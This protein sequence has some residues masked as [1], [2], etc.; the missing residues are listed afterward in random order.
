MG[1]PEESIKCQNCGNVLPPHTKFCTKC[2]TE[3]KIGQPPGESIP[4]SPPEPQETRQGE[5]QLQIPQGRGIIET[6]QNSWQFFRTHF[7]QI[8]IGVGVISLISAIA[9]IIIAFIPREFITDVDIPP[10]EGF[11]FDIFVILNVILTICKE[12]SYFW[13]ILPRKKILDKWFSLVIL[14]LWWINLITFG[15][16][17]VNTSIFYDLGGRIPTIF[18]VF[19][20][21]TLAVSFLYFARYRKPLFSST[22]VISIMTIIYLQQ[23][24]IPVDPIMY[25]AI[26]IITAMLLF[27]ITFLTKDLVPTIGVM[28][29]VPGMFLSPYILSNTSFLPISILLGLLPFIDI[30]FTKKVGE[31]ASNF[32]K[33]LIILSNVS[34]LFG[35][36]TLGFTVFYG[37]LSE[38]FFLL[39]LSIIVLM[40]LLLKLRF[41]QALLF[42]LKDWTLTLILLFFVAFFD[43]IEID[44]FILTAIAG[45]LTLFASFN[46][47]EYVSTKRPQVIQYSE[48]LLLATL[49]I[50]SITKIEFIPKSSFFILPLL[51][52]SILLY[53]GIEFDHSTVRLF[54]FGFI[55]LFIMNFLQ[56]PFYNWIIIP[57]YSLIALGGIFCVKVFHDIRNHEG[58]HIDLSIVAILLEIDLLILMLGTKTIS[59]MIYPVMMLIALVILLSGIQLWKPLNEKF[60]WVNSSF[61]ITFGLM[62]FWNEFDSIFTLLISFILLLPMALEKLSFTEL[63]LPLHMDRVNQSHNFNIALAAAGLALI[64]LFEELD[65]ISHTIL[66]LLGPII[67]VIISVQNKI[68]N[69]TNLLLIL[70]PPGFIYLSELVIRS[71]IFT[72]IS[73]EPYLYSALIVITIPAIILQGAK[74]LKKEVFSETK[75]NPFIVMTALL[76]IVITSSTWIYEL[77][78]EVVS[79][80]Y[81]VL[82]V[83]LVISSFLITWQ[84]ESILLVMI[85]FLPS[86]LFSYDVGFPQLVK[87]ILPVIPLCFNIGIVFKRMKSTLAV[88]THETLMVLYL[89]F[90]ILLYPVKI[91]E[92]TILLAALLLISWQILGVLNRRLDSSLLEITNFLNSI[93]VLVLIIFIDSYV[94]EET[95]VVGSSVLELKIIFLTLISGV[96][97]LSMLLHVIYGQVRRESV[98]L[99]ILLSGSIVTNISSLILVTVSIIIRTTDLTFDNIEIGI[100]IIT[101][102]LLMVSLLV[103]IRPSRINSDVITGFILA[104]SLWVLISSSYFQNVEIIFLWIVFAP[105]I[106]A[107]YL[108]RQDLSYL[109]VGIA[110]YTLT[111]IRLLEIILNSLQTGI[112]NWLGILGLIF[113]GVE[114]LSIGIYTVLEN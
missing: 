13:G 46:F 41:K 21:I 12:I 64:V 24:I 71:T 107:F 14:L 97:V 60:S 15:F 110:F 82:L 75:I 59:E 74:Q 111:G 39:L 90:F 93:L 84:Y 16:G 43:M 30:F 63:D 85:T 42:P 78:V 62:T 22:L 61:L 11:I 98:K 56:H 50:I 29:L 113:L 52:L 18:V 105:I 94:I 72:P 31:E 112:T 70:L 109:V 28:I 67:W 91:L 104:S 9:F 17:L 20:I 73:E 79:L 51:S 66:L 7:S 99:P 95:L 6:L 1:K 25:T 114:L 44:L 87:Y 40:F 33:G 81:L 101:S 106:V 34:S 100:L 49:T 80:L 88:K 69:S 36:I 48:F 38:E 8:F 47:F 108:N 55:L 58:F 45:I 10:V 3:I 27:F 92:Y 32:N 96:V 89:I 77:D 53:H 5:S 68:D 19:S 2:G 103:N 54:V 83:L 102:S 26:I 35:I 57:I 37:Y 23:W 86:V 65:P 4:P 76:G